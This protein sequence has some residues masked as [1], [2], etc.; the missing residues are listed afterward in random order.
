MLQATTRAGL[1]AQGESAERE[2]AQ[3]LGHCAELEC[4]CERG[5]FPRREPREE[6]P[7]AH[8]AGRKHVVH[9]RRAEDK[10]RSVLLRQL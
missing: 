4:A 3:R 8:P 9:C 10:L 5:G 1:G 6:L 2:H 7:L